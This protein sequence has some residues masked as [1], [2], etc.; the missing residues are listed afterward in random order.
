MWDTSHVV[1]I[2]KSHH[3]T[4][5]PAITC[6]VVV[7]GGW[8]KRAHKHSY[9]AKSGVGTILS[10]AT[11]CILVSWTILLLSSTTYY[12][13]VQGR[14]HITRK[15]VVQAIINTSWSTDIKPS[16][17]M[18]LNTFPRECSMFIEI[19]DLIDRTW[20]AAICSSR[21]LDPP[22]LICPKTACTLVE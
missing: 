15:L 22:V 19:G 11:N 14:L 9:N 16:S 13:Q 4:I 17:T 12:F 7:D 20:M 5:Y 10:A 21:W 2:A 3:N 8:N 18:S 1:N 6:T